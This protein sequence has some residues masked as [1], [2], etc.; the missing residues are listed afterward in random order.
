VRKDSLSCNI[1]LVIE[2]DGT[3]YE[4]WQS[5]KNGNTIQDIIT[6]KIKILTGED[7]NLI[8]QGR[9]D[10]GVHALAQTA[11]FHL[12]KEWDLDELLN[13]LNSLL[14]DDICIKAVKLVP[15]DFHSR[16]D[17][18][19]RIYEYRILTGKQRDC[20]LLKYS[21]HIPFH[22]DIDKMKEA[23]RYFIGEHDFSSFRAKS[24]SSNNPVRTIQRIELFEDGRL[25]RINLEANAFLQH[26][27]RLIV[28]L[29]I[30]VGSCRFEP[31][32]AK[33]ILECKDIDKKSFMSFRNA[34]AKGLFLVEVKYV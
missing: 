13:A 19:S 30:E 31:D 16:F 14:P 9:T 32:Y 2:Y 18:K 22:I 15:D 3:N 25:L 11:N 28:G 27:V 1:F 29:L 12:Q 5:Q 10:S 6:K 21:W 20:F 23:T 7:I 26:M 4:G 24:C 34:P 17:A 8:G 33:F